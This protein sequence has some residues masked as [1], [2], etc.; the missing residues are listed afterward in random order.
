[1]RKHFTFAAC[2]LLALGAFTAPTAAMAD[3]VTFN[4]T[5]SD[6]CTVTATGTGTMTAAANGLSIGTEESGGSAAALSVSAV[7][8]PP[9]VDFTAPSVTSAPSGYTGTPTASIKFNSSGASGQSTYTS[10]ASSSQLTA[11]DW[12]AAT[13]R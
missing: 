8:T 2:S 1:M 3:T 11:A 4:G 5:L 13:T 7:G 12:P 10:A 9:Q 6:S